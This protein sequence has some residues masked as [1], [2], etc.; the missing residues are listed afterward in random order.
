MKM[1]NCIP[2]MKAWPVNEWSMHR[3]INID[4]EK[5]EKSKANFYRKKEVKF[6][7]LS[8]QKQFTD[9]TSKNNSNKAIYKPEKTQNID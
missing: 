7:R 4:F 2:E 3:S 9:S 8:D 6:S 5:Q 1:T